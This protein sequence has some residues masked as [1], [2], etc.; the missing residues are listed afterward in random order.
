MGKDDYCGAFIFADVTLFLTPDAHA[1][2]CIAYCC[3]G[4]QFFVPRKGNDAI[5]AYGMDDGID[6]PVLHENA[7]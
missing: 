4:G 5:A 2:Q 3:I 7:T 6:R 1:A